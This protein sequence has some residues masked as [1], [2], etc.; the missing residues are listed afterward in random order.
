MITCI[1]YEN[2]SEC[3]GAMTA[4]LRLRHKIFIERENYHV[5]TDKVRSYNRME[6]DQYDTPAAIYLTYLSPHGEAWGCSRLTPVSHGSMIKDTWPELVEAPAEIFVEG[7]WEGT[8]FCVDHSL[9]ASMR[10]QICRELVIAYLEAGLEIGIQRVIG[11]M[12][13]AIL[14]RVF[15]AAGCPFHN[16]GPTLRISNGETIAA[17]CMQ[18]SEQVLAQ[19][20]KISGIAE[21]VLHFP[22]ARATQVLA[23]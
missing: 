7:V 17:G 16:L 2:L 9:P 23:A 19:A 18:V 3:G 14:K 6:H 11:V 4:M 13:P 20:K 8:R 22:L 12:Q 1:S 21:S 10:R 5:G 15:S